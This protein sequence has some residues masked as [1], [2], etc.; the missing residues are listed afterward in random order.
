MGDGHAIQGDG[1]ANGTAAET[2]LTGSFR[3][4][5][6]KNGA[7]LPFPYAELDGALVTLAVNEDLNE[8]A[9]SAIQ[10]AVSAVAVRFAISMSD[11]YRHVSLCSDL[12][13]SQLV[14][15]KKGVHCRVDVSA[16]SLR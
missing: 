2:A 6:V 7:F 15:I 13:I 10:Q 11:A 14:N 1:E 5:T 8:A 3:F 12:T 16:L 4:E 9:R